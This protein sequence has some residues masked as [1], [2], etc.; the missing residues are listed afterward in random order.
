MAF[1]KFP[2]PKGIF[3]ILTRPVNMTKRARRTVLE[4]RTCHHKK[5]RTAKYIED[6][7][8]RRQTVVLLHVLHLVRHVHRVLALQLHVPV[9]GLA[10]RRVV[11]HY[12]QHET[13]TRHRFHES[14]ALRVR[15]PDVANNS[16]LVELAGVVFDIDC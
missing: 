7:V 14:L 2:T 3:R 8:A 10:D 15:R 11:E 9:L 1:Q 6:V 13:P 5:T 16:L 12:G 4:L